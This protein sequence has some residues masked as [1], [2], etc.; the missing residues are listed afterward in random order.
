MWIKNIS[1]K[2][3]FPGINIYETKLLK[4]GSALTLPG[5]GIFI[6]VDL[7]G[8]LKTRMLQHEYGHYLDY[9]SI[10]TNRFYRFIKFYFFI[11]LPSFINA[12]IGI[13]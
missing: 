11:G 3:S 6:H 9:L 10:S 8:I 13:G 5:I 12:A 4:S 7:K 2:D 1:D